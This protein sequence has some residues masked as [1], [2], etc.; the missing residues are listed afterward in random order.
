M[1]TRIALLAC[2]LLLGGC[3]TVEVTKMGG[4]TT[5]RH[6]NDDPD[7]EDTTE[8]QLVAKA[9]ANPDSPKGWFKLGEFYERYRDFPRAIQAYENMLLAHQKMTKETG[10]K[11]TSSLYLLGRC[12]SLVKSWGPAVDYLK[13]VLALQPKTVQ[14]TFSNPDFLESHYLLGA[15][16]FEHRMYED[17]EKHLISFQELAPRDDH[18]AD[19]LLLKIDEELRPENR[20][21]THRPAQPLEASKKGESEAPSKT[22]AGET[23]SKSEDG[24]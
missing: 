4:K 14:L 23:P 9:E 12:H 13:Q 3:E 18:R 11:Y 10:T 1:S 17:A 16:Y 6:V 24:R 7:F 19:G 20:R 15:I 2:L 21:R 22:D 5:V 8:G